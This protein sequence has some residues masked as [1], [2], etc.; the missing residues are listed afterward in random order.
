MQRIIEGVAESKIGR[1]MTRLSLVKQ[2]V[3]E[4]GV[5]NYGELNFWQKIEWDGELCQTNRKIYYQ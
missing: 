3:R 1:D 5:K 2:M 4:D